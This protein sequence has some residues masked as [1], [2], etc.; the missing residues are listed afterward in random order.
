M[1]WLIASIH[2]TAA[3]AD[4][5]ATAVVS[6]AILADRLKLSRTHL[7]RKLKDAEALGS[8]GWYGKRGQSVMWVSAGFLREYATAQAVKLTIIDSAF[9]ACFRQMPAEALPAASTMPRPR[10]GEALYDRA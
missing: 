3:D 1:G 6:I 2:E 10:G 4:R 9:A 5:V 7:T 8:V